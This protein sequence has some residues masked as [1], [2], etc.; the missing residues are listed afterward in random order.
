MYWIIFCVL[1]FIVFLAIDIWRKKQDS[2]NEFYM[3]WVTGVLLLV[4]VFVI[5]MSC[6]SYRVAIETFETKKIT[7]AEQRE[8]NVN[9][10]EGTE[11]TEYIAN[12][13]AWLAGLQFRKKRNF[14]NWYI[15]KE[16]LEV[17]PIK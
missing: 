11:L 5:P 6:E 1:I 7:I 15:P 12:E 2:F 13:N 16:I 9:S 4:S 3:S 17:E 8:L 14:V 10:H